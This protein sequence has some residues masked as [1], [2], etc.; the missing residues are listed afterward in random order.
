M[1]FSPFFYSK[2][3]DWIKLKTMGNDKWEVADEN[4]SDVPIR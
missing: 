4:I 1:F 2:L 3:S